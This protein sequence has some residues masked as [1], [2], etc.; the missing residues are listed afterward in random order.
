[1]LYQYRVC[2]LQKIDIRPSSG[3]ISMLI[4]VSSNKS[5]LLYK[6]PEFKKY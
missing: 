6:F 5:V 1:M 3:S 4:R 2:I